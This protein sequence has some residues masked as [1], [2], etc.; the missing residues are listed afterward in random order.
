MSCGKP[1]TPTIIEPPIDLP[2]VIPP[3]VTP[4]IYIAGDSIGPLSSSLPY[5]VYWKDGRLVSLPNASYSSASGIAVTDSNGY[6][7]NSG[8]FL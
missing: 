2:P 7:S 1:E 8:M 5:A 4:G 6:V 3:R